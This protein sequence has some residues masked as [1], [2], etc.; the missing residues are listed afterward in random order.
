MDD[1]QFKDFVNKDYNSFSN[2]LFSLNA[3]EFSLF[4][5]AA[6]FLI[7]PSLTINQQNSLGNFFE[8]LGQVILTINA[9]NT[10]K[11]Q[12]E[13]QHSSIKEG[14]EELTLEQEILKL[15]KEV[16]QLREDVMGNTK[17]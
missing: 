5:T 11:M 12:K 1:Q 13:K 17:Y 2:W 4:A 7:S 14:F 15:K 8:L 3:Y 16:I 9:Q 6:G 10:T